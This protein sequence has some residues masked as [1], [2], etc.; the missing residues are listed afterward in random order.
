MPDR[1][2]EYRKSALECLELARTI[3]DPTVRASLLV[4]A[5]KWFEL[6]TDRPRGRAVLDAAVRGF[7][8]DRMSSQPSEQQQQNQSEDAPKKE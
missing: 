8:E 4:M 3:A 2:D 5:E 1:S 6:A 7:T